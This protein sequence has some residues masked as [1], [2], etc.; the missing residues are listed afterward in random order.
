MPK[1]DRTGPRGE[2]PLSGRGMGYCS[3][4]DALEYAQP[5]PGMGRGFARGRG[6][7]RR[8][9]RH[10][11][12]ATGLPRWAR[13]GSPAG[14]SEPQVGDTAQEVADLKAHADWLGRQLGA[15]QAR[16]EALT[17]KPE[18]EDEV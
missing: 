11:F 10:W 2:G 17:N 9:Y 1:G 13:Y 7:Q 14:A 16:L 12:H 8:G 6:D 5:G 4:A 3:G 18:G 15:I